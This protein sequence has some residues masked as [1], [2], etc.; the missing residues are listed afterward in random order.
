MEFR[1]PRSSRHKFRAPLPPS[2]I[3]PGTAEVRAAGRA[4]RVST[5]RGPDGT[6]RNGTG[7]DG[8]GGGGRPRA[9]DGARGV[10][11]GVRSPGR[12][13]GPGSGRPL[14]QKSAGTAVTSPISPDVFPRRLAELNI[15][16]WALWGVSALT[17]T[18]F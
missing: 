2:L 15:P 17:S 14:L 10:V 7:R 4:E 16:Q 5:Q 3:G 6:G 13:L 11:P 18:R 9:G 1:P 8:K 12:V